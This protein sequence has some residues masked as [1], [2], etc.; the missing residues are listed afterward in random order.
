MC[1]DLFVVFSYYSFDG[2]RV[3][4]AIRCFI[5]DICNLCLLSFSLWL[6]C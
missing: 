5:P 3:S 6:F 2:Y 1:V 4:S